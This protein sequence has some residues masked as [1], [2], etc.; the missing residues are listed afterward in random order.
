MSRLATT[1]MVLRPALAGNGAAAENPLAAPG[2]NEKSASRIGR[3]DST[4]TPQGA[5]DRRLALKMAVGRG[6]SQVAAAYFPSLP[7]RR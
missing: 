1:A 7:S 3:E 2:L 5:S 4:K 6:H